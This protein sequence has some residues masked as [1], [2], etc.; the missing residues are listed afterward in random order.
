[1][2]TTRPDTLYGVTF[3][4]VAPE[5]PIAREAALRDPL[6]A[7]YL[8][9]TARLAERQRGSDAASMD[10][11]F[12]GFY[13]VHPLT[14]APIPIWTGS[15]VLAGYGTGA[16]MAVPAHDS[17]DFAFARAHQLPI[18]VVIQPDG[19]APLDPGSMADAYT[20]AGT[21]SLPRI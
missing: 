16:V 15:F 12:T 4:T 13:A 18:K 19:F 7:A 1:M 5:H 14:G 3:L 10:G 21:W 2:F 6:V 20:G 9:E 17:R 11:V 8:E